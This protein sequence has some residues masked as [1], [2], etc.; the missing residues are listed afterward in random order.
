M[1]YHEEL[2]I[3]M[4]IKANRQVIEGMEVKEVFLMGVM[5]CIT[6]ILCALYYVTFADPIGT[7]F[8]G[9]AILLSS[10]LI[11]KKSEKDNQSFLD[12]LSHIISYYRGRKHYAYIHLN[13]WE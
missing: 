9:L 13:E 7:F 1:E 2:Y 6:V 4:G 8:G 10:Y 12:M 5:V 3:P 11:L